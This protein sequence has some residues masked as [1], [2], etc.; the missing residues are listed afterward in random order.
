MKKK[1]GLFKVLTVLLLLVVV[2]TYFID[3]RQG[4]VS[5]LA[6][7]DV[8]LNYIQSF[9]YFFDTAIFILAVGGFYGLL[10]RIPAYKKFV[11]GIASK[12]ADKDKG[13][14]FIILTTILFALLSS[15]TGLNFSLLLFVP[16]VI[17]IILVLGYDKLVALSA[18]IGGVLVGFIGGVFVTFKDASSQYAVSYTTFDKMVGLDSHWA[19]LFPKILLL[20]LVTGLL[21]FTIISHIKKTERGESKYKLTTNDNLFVEVKDRTG[22]KVQVDDENVRVW[23]FVV[24][25]VLLLVLLVL[26]YLPWSSLF[27]IDCFDK[28]HTWLTGLAIGDYTVFTNLISSSFT[29]FGDWGSLGSYM[30][31]IFLMVFFG[32]IL[33]LIYRVKFEDAMDGFIYGVKK[34]IP[35]AMIAMLAYCV[36]VCSYNNGFVETIITKAQDSFGDNVVIHSLITML[37]SVLNVDLYYTTAGVFT[38][39]TSG[40]SDSANL[41]V[42]AV[43]FQSLYGL[44]QIVGPTS[45]LL[46]VGLSY[47]E[48]P[49]KTWF[50][51]IWRFVV[52][53]L[54]IIFIILMIVSLL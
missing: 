44:V 33:M 12:V 20:V 22:K 8:F 29:A 18:T 42:Y 53:L 4:E 34:L 26:G 17:S 7:G 51:Y 2:A 52:E 1:Y 54:I 31:A 6:L 38:S 30:M 50:K 32:F 36:L 45:L 5:Y 40:L 46:I 14:L 16:F 43:M 49:Y 11:N 19:N 47:L 13:K 24:M 23:P 15:L 25:L 37:G 35:A 28:F 27:G 39:I 48:V 41:S 9:Y 3:S 10:N 21:I